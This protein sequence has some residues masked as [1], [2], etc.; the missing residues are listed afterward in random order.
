MSFRLWKQFDLPEGRLGSL[1]RGKSE[2]RGGFQ[3]FSL[4]EETEQ[5]PRR[6]RAQRTWEYGWES[7]IYGDVMGKR[8][9]GPACVNEFGLRLTGK[10]SLFQCWGMGMD[11]MPI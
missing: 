11:L 8:Q 5:R 7:S 10:V 1:L 4:R 6:G 2:E 9:E 3:P